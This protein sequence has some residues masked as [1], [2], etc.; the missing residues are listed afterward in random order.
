MGKTIV[1]I[2]LGVL[3]LGLIILFFKKIKLVWQ[4][5]DDIVDD[6]LKKW[7]EVRKKLVWSRTSLTMAVSFGLSVYMALWDMYKNGFNHEIFWAFLGVGVGVKLVD[8]A[9]RKMTNVATPPN[10]DTPPTK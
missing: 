8:A 6:T 9:S 2:L 1:F 7:D 5:L 4:T 10:Q 3:A